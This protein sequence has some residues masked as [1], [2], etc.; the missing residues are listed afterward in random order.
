[1]V[2]KDLCLSDVSLGEFFTSIY[3]LW[4]DLRTR[5]DD[6]FMVVAG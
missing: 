3:A 4:L 6:G 2:C 5:N 1:M